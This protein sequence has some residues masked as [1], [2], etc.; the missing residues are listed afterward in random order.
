MSLFSLPSPF[1]LCPFSSDGCCVH[2]PK[3]A[4]VPSSGPPPTMQ[5]TAEDKESNGKRAREEDGG[6]SEPAAKKV[7]TKEGSTTEAA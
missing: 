6:A 7:D 1:E 3:D 4:N 2:G 5:S